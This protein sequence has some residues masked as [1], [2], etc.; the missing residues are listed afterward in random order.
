MEH[1]IDPD[2]LGNIRPDSFSKFG[3]THLSTLLNLVH[4][5]STGEVLRN[6]ENA[7]NLQEPVIHENSTIPKHAY[8]CEEEEIQ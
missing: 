1:I 8:A 7:L 2:F 5:P 6:L 4:I 3:E